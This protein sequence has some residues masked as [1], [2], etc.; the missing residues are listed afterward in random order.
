[1]VS[2]NNFKQN[3]GVIGLELKNI[4]KSFGS[5]SALPDKGVILLDG[6]DISN[7]PSQKRNLGLVFQNY[8]LFPHMNVFDN[9]A[10]GLRRRHWPKNRITDKVG[11]ALKLVRLAG[12]EERRIHELSGGQQQRI[13]LACSLVI[14]PRLLL[15]DEPLSNLDA[16]LRAD[17]RDEIKRI[18]RS[19]DL[20][21]IYVTHDQEEALSIADRVVVMNDGE[22]DQA[23]SPREIYDKT[24]TKFVA[25]LSGG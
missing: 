5:F 25:V 24:A 16:R 17:V 6:R 20:T 2:E 12:Y 19:L 13:A 8:A 14:E 22:I 1:M 15:L 7:V 4:H 3:A 21:T 10:Y 18:Q 9:V 23:G 11:E